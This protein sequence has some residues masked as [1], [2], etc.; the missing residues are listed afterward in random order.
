MLLSCDIFF[1]PL[2]LRVDLK[3][4]NFNA[5]GVDLT[6]LDTRLYMKVRVGMIR[7]IAWLANTFTLP[8]SPL[9]LSH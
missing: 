9:V 3:A 5:F 8:A 7:Q 6:R 1:G 2:Q 4:T